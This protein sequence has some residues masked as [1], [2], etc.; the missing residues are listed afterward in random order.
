MKERHSLLK[1]QNTGPPVCTITKKDSGFQDDG[2]P[3]L[4]PT[5]KQQL[6]D[7]AG[8]E[9]IEIEPL[10]KSPNSEF[11]LTPPIVISSHDEADTESPS[12]KK[13]I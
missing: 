4:S 7:Q 11:T 5:P 6:L 13:K 2:I 1:K 3:L 9:T 8:I 10:T 12:K